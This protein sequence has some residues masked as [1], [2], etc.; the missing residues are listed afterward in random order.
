VDVRG[1]EE[2]LLAHM[3]EFKCPVH[4]CL[5]QEEVPEALSQFLRKD[6]WLF[7]THRSHGHYLAKGGDPQKLWDEIAGLETGI[8]GGFSGSMSYSDPS[9]NFHASAI[10]GG[11]IGVATGTALALKGSGSIVV[12]CIGDAATEEGVFWESINFS[13][14]KKLPI[15]FI[16][17]NNQYSTHVHIKERQAT[18]IWKRVHSFGMNARTHLNFDVELPCFVEVEVERKCAHANNMV[19]FRELRA[20]NQ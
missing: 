1:F 7:S 15:L 3:D 2:K 14:V 4:L 11:L 6:D 9:I 12:C 5:G 13:V 17:E 19:D 10:V 8:N 20:V 16:C 18:P